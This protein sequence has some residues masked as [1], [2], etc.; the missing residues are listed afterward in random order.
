MSMR[1]L[2]ALLLTIVFAGAWNTAQALPIAFSFDG[3]ILGVDVGNAFGLLVGDTV[4]MSGTY[5]DIFHDGTGID[6]VPFGLGTGNLL[7]IVLGAITVFESN[8]IDFLGGFFPTLLL[9]N[10]LLAGTDIVMEIG[11]NGSP[12]D[13][14]SG[15][16]FGGADAAGLGIVGRW[17]VVAIPEPGTVAL[18]S[19]GVLAFARARRMT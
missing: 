2:R 7:T 11:E 19:L 16:F 8:D 17:N 15:V 3:E 18:L 14:D 4:T 10:G 6:E 12:I 9:K 1:N 5:D 13:F